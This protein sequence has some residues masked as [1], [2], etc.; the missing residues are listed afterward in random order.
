MAAAEAPAEAPADVQ[1]S[2]SEP[3]TEADSPPNQRGNVAPC[4]EKWV[5]V[6]PR[7]PRRLLRLL[8]RARQAT[9]LNP[10]RAPKQAEALTNS[11]RAQVRNKLIDLAESGNSDVARYGDMIT[12]ELACTRFLRGAKGN[13]DKAVEMFETHLTW[14]SRYK[15]ET[16]VD[17][18]FSDLKAHNELY[19]GGQ[20]R[21]GVMTLMWNLRKHDA[22]RTDAKRFVRFFIHQIETGLRT[23]RSY[24]NGLFNIAV[25]LDQVVRSHLAYFTCTHASALQPDI[26]I[27]AQCSAP[28]VTLHGALLPPPALP[29]APNLK[30]YATTRQALRNGKRSSAQGS[31][32]AL[33]LAF[34]PSDA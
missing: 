5:Q 9:V 10:K 25:D 26:C 33:V 2:G 18:D 15:V 31:T 12:S 11:A 1:R 13:V 21:E 17:E 3:P 30:K 29:C 24:P 7:P 23:C 32:G 4:D 8:F 34:R 22:K 28:A 14:R 19:W 6:P 20:D 16:I 27:C